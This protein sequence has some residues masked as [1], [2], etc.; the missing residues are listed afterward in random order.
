MI[1]M[2]FV[3]CFGCVYAAASDDTDIIKIDNNN[4]LIDIQVV[5]QAQ[6]IKKV[7]IGLVVVGAVD[8]DLTKCIDRLKKDLEW[9]AQAAIV[10][11][12][13]EKMTH[14]SDLKD[15]FKGSLFYNTKKSEDIF[16]F[17]YLPN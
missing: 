12:Y 13:K 3:V 17:F 7:A 5:A 14:E 1:A 15:L 10:V 2:M 8:S 6:R 4:E 9:S 11:K 16:S